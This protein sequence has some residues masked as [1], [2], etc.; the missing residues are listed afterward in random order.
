MHCNVYDKFYSKFSQ[1]HISAAIAAIFRV[2]LLKEYK[3]TNVVSYVDVTPWQLKIVI[4]S[5]KII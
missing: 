5:G 4:T 3:C 1:Q 2:M